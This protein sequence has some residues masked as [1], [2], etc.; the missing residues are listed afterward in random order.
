SISLFPILFALL[1]R[2]RHKGCKF[3]LEIRDIWPLTLIEIGNYSPY[4]PFVLLLAFIEKLGY[5]KADYLVSNLPN[6]NKHFKEVLGDRP[7]KF[8]WISNGMEIGD[9]LEE[10]ALDAQLAA[11]IDPTTFN[12]GYAGTIGQANA[13]EYLIEAAHT[14]ASNKRV[15]IY[16][17]GSGYLKEELEQRVAD[18]DNIVFLGR[19]PHQQV[20]SFLKKMDLLYLS[21]Q[22]SPLYRFGVSANKIFDYMYAGV[23]ILM[24]GEIPSN[25]ISLSDCGWVIPPED[26]Q[27]II[28]GIN[29][30]VTLPER[31]LEQKG[32]NGRTAVLEQFSYSFLASKYGNLFKGLVALSP[33]REKFVI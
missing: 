14:L 29:S 19:I 18:L 22:N 25:P 2:W 8:E 23:P 27:A 16:I 26:T 12:V 4:N 33:S 20:Q 13:M 17:V 3:I 10:Q 7:I 11:Q 30:I 21:W 15:K 28:D 31:E 1:Y 9:G 32:Q 5:Q 24:S 6:A